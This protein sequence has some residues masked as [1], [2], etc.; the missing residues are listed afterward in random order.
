MKEAE[1]SLTYDEREIVWRN[2]FAKKLGKLLLALMKLELL[3]LMVSLSFST[4]FFG[5]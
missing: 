2:L 4:N 1:D 5:Q 3:V